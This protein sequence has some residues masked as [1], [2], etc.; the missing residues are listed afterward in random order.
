VFAFKDWRIPQWVVL[1]DS[2]YPFGDLSPES[3]LALEPKI[4]YFY[5]TSNWFLAPYNVSAPKLEHPFRRSNC[6][7]IPNSA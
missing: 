1:G 7:G 4:C 3:P 5:M 2:V 6:H